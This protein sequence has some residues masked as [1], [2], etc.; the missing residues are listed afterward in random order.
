MLIRW[1]LAP[2]IL[3]DGNGRLLTESNPVDQLSASIHMSLG[4][5]LIY[6]S[7]EGTG[8]EP[9]LTGYFDY[10]LLGQFSISGTVQVVPSGLSTAD[11]HADGFVDGADTAMLFCNWGIP[12]SILPQ[13]PAKNLASV[14]YNPW[15]G[16]II[17]SANHN[18]TTWTVESLSGGLSA[19]V[20]P[21]SIPLNDG[22]IT[23]TSQRVQ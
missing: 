17:I 18:N 4:P 16:E 6:L 14:S 11:L 21:A 20:L 2:R 10:E 12:P 15:T 19:G 5:G 1:D 22:I 9:V 3:Y 8:N 7:V 23:N 13:S